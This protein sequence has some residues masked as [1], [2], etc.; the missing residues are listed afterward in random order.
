MK[1][2]LDYMETH[3]QITDK[4]LES[5]L[6]VKKT[7]VFNLTKEMKERGLIDSVGRGRDKRFLPCKTRFR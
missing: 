1:A 5:L 6:G 4:E 2:V 7:R 3:G